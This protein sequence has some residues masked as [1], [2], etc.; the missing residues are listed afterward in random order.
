MNGYIIIDGNSIAHAANNGTPLKMGN[1]PTNAIY[2]FLRTIRRLMAVYSAYTPIVLW[3]G[4]SW[5]K[6]LFSDYKANRELA[7]TIHERKALAAKDEL[8][9]QKPFIEKSLRYLGVT[10]IRAANMEADDLAAILTDRYRAASKAAIVLVTADK[11]W[12]QLVDEGVVWL[13]LINDRKVNVANFEEFTGVETRRQ[14][15]EM[16]ALTGDQGDNIAGVGGIGEK[17]AIEFLSTYQTFAN[18][19]NLAMDASFDLAGLPKKFRLLAEDE[20]KRIAFSRNLEL[21]DLRT[22]A[23]PKPVGLSV[24]KGE[25]SYAHFNN[26]CQKLMF[27]SITDDLDNWLSVIPAYANDSMKNNDMEMENGK[28]AS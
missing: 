21:V 7:N 24:D 20:G 27:K 13:D 8:T 11:D 9:K 15:I 14:F 10:Q 5:R 12:I 6:M 22:T 1:L 16:K 4:A 26:F 19:S 25:P 28:I 3:D 23:R 18:F 2:G 17:G